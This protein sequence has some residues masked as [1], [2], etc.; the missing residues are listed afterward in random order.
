M[1]LKQLGLTNFLSFDSYGIVL[2]NKGLL[3]VSG[4]NGSGKSSL[5]SKAITW[6]LFGQTPEGIKGDSVIRSGTDRSEVSLVLDNL[7]IIRQRPHSLKFLTDSAVE[8][9]EFRS[10]N[11]AQDFI[12]KSIHRDFTTFIN[13]DYFGQ[14]RKSKFINE[15]AR[16][17]LEILEE[18]L[19]LDRIDSILELTKNKIFTL[20][21]YVDSYKISVIKYQTE[22]EMLVARKA[23]LSSD[24]ASQ[25]SILENEEQSL[26]TNIAKKVNDSIKVC[27]VFDLDRLKEIAEEK[28]NII[29]DLESGIRATQLEINNVEAQIKSLKSKVKVIKDE[30][31]PTCDQQVNKDL[32]DKLIKDQEFN[33]LS[34]SELLNNLDVHIN[35]KNNL[36]TNL[37]S[38]RKEL[39]SINNDI[40]K[41]Q[42]VHINYD[43]IIATNK[44]VIAD[45]SSKISLLEDQIIKVQDNIAITSSWLDGLKQDL[46]KEES[47]LQ[48][49]K[50]W[51]NIFSKD[52]KNF[53]IQETLPFIEERTRYHLNLL[54]N[55]HINVKFSTIKEL[56]NG[57]ER[58]LFNI[59][60]KVNNGGSEY[61]SLSGGEKQ[62]VSFAI[63]LTLSEL[64]D[65]QNGESS[66]IMI[67]DEP[68]TE[69]DN[70]NCENIINYLN[71]ELLKKKETIILISNDDRMKSLVNNVIE[72]EKDENGISRINE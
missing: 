13:A 40:A 4:K 28:K 38:F 16:T 57:E 7:T 15:S 1:R 24:L 55:S 52:F 19:G 70:T 5:F 27:V 47:Y 8:Y 17:Q 61:S 42:V 46:K 14:D 34:L 41:L 6:A 58:S 56:K 21:K 44:K 35:H 72:I 33:S 45:A 10:A 20:I 2:A 71:N 12:N 65:M 36:F 39:D 51:Q 54:N 63:G 30:V 11:E 18:I 59:S 66:N 49:I 53:I 26:K 32:T 43:N 50:F 9:T 3:L 68:F 69:L 48:D 29:K 25:K 62:I 60:Y 37:I 31:C 23:K 22:L 64:V 67:L